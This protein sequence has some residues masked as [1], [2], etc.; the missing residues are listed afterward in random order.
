MDRPRDYPTKWSKS[1]KD[2]YYMISLVCEIWKKNRNELI[3]KTETDTDFEN[4]LVVTKGER[5]GEG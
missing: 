3:Y 2:K 4:K 1:D 5:W